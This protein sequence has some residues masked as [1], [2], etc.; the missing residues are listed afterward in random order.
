MTEL[1]IFQSYIKQ[2]GFERTTVFFNLILKQ[3]GLE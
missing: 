3:H 2:H 1:G